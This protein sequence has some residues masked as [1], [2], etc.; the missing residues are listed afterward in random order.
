MESFKYF[1]KCFSFFFNFYRLFYFYEF[2]SDFNH[3][4]MFLTRFICIKKEK[5]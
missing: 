4:K 3:F 2:I 1:E 5:L